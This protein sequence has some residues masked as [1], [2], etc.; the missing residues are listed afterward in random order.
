MPRLKVLL[1]TEAANPEWVSVPLVG[2]NVAAALR[3]VADVHIVTQVRNREA[4]LRKGLVE[5]Q[6]FTAIDSEAIAAPFYRL[7]Q[8]LRGGAGKGWTTLTAI[9][10][11]TY[12]YFEYLVWQQ[13]GKA[14]VSGAYDIVH[15]VTPLSPTSPSSLAAKCSRA[16]VPF[17]LGPLN[18]GLPWPKGFNEARTKEKEWL[19]FVRSIYS[20]NPA[21][22]ATYRN[23]TTIIVGSRHTQSEVAG[24]GTPTVYIPENGIDPQSFQAVHEV[25]LTNRK[26]KAIFVGRLVPYKGADVAIEACAEAMHK[27]RLELEIVG[28]GPEMQ[29]LTRLAHDLGVS[30]WVTFSGWLPHSEVPSRLAAADIL[31]FP[32]IRE[33]GGGVVLEAMACG[34]VPIVVDYGGPGELVTAQTGFRIP[35]GDKEGLILAT[36]R[37]VEQLLEEPNY[38]K[39]FSAAARQRVA[40]LYTWGKKAD[41]IYSVYLTAKSGGAAG[42]GFAFD[43]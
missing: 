21:I 14:I 29:G 27:K 15:R 31:V 40:D 10:S 41:Q 8:R 39:D 1:I 4:F 30:K 43:D 20:F 33:F 23:A 18:G 37:V 6:D 35:L 38:L 5:G 32:S 19:S 25:P 28:D 13:F 3:Q 9:Q 34:T 2:W 42:L 11:L 7:A 12:P 16:N 24:Y 17:I 36:I 22:K 26:L